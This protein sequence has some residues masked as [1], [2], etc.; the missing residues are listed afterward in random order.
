[1]IVDVGVLS[2]SFGKSE[3]YPL[4]NLSM[5]TQVDEIEKARH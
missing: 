2:D 1:M 4:W 3:I 5:M